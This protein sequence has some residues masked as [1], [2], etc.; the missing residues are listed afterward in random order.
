MTGQNEEGAYPIDQRIG[1]DIVVVGELR[2]RQAS[3]LL[4]RLFQIGRL[5][6]HLVAKIRGKQYGVA[7]AVQ[8][9]GRYLSALPPQCLGLVVVSQL[10]SSLRPQSK[11]DIHIPEGTPG[12]ARR[13]YRECLAT[14]DMTVVSC[15]AQQTARR[16]S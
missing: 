2:Q 6:R 16:S 11:A 14:E 8:Q 12:C 10:F 1:Y 3:L 4:Q 15:N 5:W 7:G 9:V 13:L